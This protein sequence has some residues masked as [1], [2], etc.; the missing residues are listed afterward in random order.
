[1]ATLRTLYPDVDLAVID[2][3]STGRQEALIGMEIETFEGSILDTDLLARSARGVD[4]IVHLAARP[5]VPRSILDPRASHEVN[6]TG[7]LNVLE[8][9]REIGAHVTVASSSSVYGANLGMPKHEGLAQMPMSPYAV[10]K[11]ACEGYAN[12]WSHAYGLGTIAFRFFNVYGPGQLAG[13]AYAAVIPA[14][15]SQVIFG[16]PICVYGDGRQSRD[17][18]FV[19]TVSNLLARTTIEQRVHST[20]VNLALGTRTSLNELI[21][22]IAD[23]THVSPQVVYESTRPGD[24]EHS[25]ADSTELRSLFPDIPRVTIEE[26]VSRTYAWLQ[27]QR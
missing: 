24:V 6:A 26:G 20:P 14:F 17:F 1:M 10:S 25:C 2:D 9:A 21:D 12:A 13:H 15:L 16:K 23:V 18:T 7:T 19:G 5:S 11:L 27:T 3:F 22:I 4:S 8:A